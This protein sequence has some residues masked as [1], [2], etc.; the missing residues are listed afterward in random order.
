LRAAISRRVAVLRRLVR[1][2]LA[3][4]LLVLV[5]PVRVLANIGGVPGYSGNPDTD[6]GQTCN[7]CH[8][9]GSAPIV[10]LGGP[11]TIPGGETRTYLL[12]IQ[13]TSTNAHGCGLSVSASSGD[14]AATE[15]DTQL[16]LEHV[17][18]TAPRPVDA[19]GICTYALNWTAPVAAGTATLYAAGNSVNLDGTQ[20]G[21]DRATTTTLE[22]NV[23][24]APFGDLPPIADA[25]GPHSAVTSESI[26]FDGTASVD[27]DGTIVFYEWDFGDGQIGSGPNPSHSYASPG[28]YVVTLTTTDNDGYTDW[29]QT[30]ATIFAEPPALRAVRVI[31]SNALGGVLQAGAPQGDPRL[32]IGL[33]GTHGDGVP[34][35]LIF[36]E[37]ALLPTPFV[38]LPGRLRGFNFAPD[39]AS[40][41]LFYVWYIN[42]NGDGELA[43]Y[44]VSVDPN[45]ADPGSAEILLVVPTARGHH[46]GA[47]LHFGPDGYLYLGVGD[48]LA[49]D[50]SPQ[51]G[52][53]LRGK[54]VRLDVSG[55]LG[56]GYSIPPDN[57]YV[58][59]PAILDEIWAFG[60][61]NP[62]RWDIDTLTGDIYYTDVGEGRREEVSVEPAGSGGGRNYGW[63]IL[64]GTFCLS[65]PDAPRCYDGTLEMPIHEYT[66]DDGR[67]AIIGGELYR[68]V[69]PEL[70]GRF[71]FGDHCTGQ[72]FSLLWDG[73][74]GVVD[75]VD[76][77]DDLIPDVGQVLQ[78]TSVSRGG[79]GELYLV[80]QGGAQIFRI[81]S[82]APDSDDDGVP[83][84]VDNC[85]DDPNP[86]QADQDGDGTG[87]ACDDPC[88]DGVDNDLDGVVDLDD[89]G[90]DSA[91]DASERSGILACDDGVD[92][93]G[94]GR[95]DFD[96]ETF[97]DPLFLAGSGDPG[98]GS[99]TWG[100][101]SPACDNGEDDDGDL[102]VDWA[103][104]P[105]GEE[106]DPQCRRGPFGKTEARSYCGLG[107]ELMLLLPLLDA[108]RR[109]R[110][111]RAARCPRS[112]A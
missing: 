38:T 82:S 46:Y 102:R 11:T 42:A 29:D 19:A 41:G 6:L 105:G 33:R 97:G 3:W 84:E 21:Y 56:S 63:R 86:S 57:P 24:G 35:I 83:D 1:F 59:D 108:V 50:D 28:T 100:T 40:S 80:D 75:V 48:G 74:D 5:F 25:N 18:H 15:V 73:A 65:T 43:R 67:C 53:T 55:G 72:I 92:N 20:A 89:P 37:G 78:L 69:I 54:V 14:L 58:D 103:G 30:T 77:S 109:K 94:D 17:T 106:P 68:G 47:D 96:P 34:K 87:D 110:A 36:E 64:E 16:W 76:H 79:F 9:P 60:F 101:E 45:L 31:Q 93:D 51:N 90:C 81:L 61:R 44:R 23:D 12:T 27:V 91:F 71:F 4:A 107:A 95:V 98:C 85:F 22:I 104:G 88:D 7:V 39:Y 13:R 8:N 10:S 62:Y 112:R 111:T 70:Q 32:F 49:L 66:H 2:D 52:G 99:P 26:V